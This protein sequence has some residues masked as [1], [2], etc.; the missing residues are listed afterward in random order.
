[1]NVLHPPQI[2]N[3][4]RRDSGGICWLMT[5]TGVGGWGSVGSS[6]PLFQAPGSNPCQCFCRFR[7]CGCKGLGAAMEPLSHSPVCSCA[8]NVGTLPLAPTG[9][10]WLSL[11]PPALADLGGTSLR[12]PDLHSAPH[13]ETMT[14]VSVIN[15]YSAISTGNAC[16]AGIG[17]STAATENALGKLTFGMRS[18]CVLQPPQRDLHAGTSCGTPTA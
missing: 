5:G 3:R 4:P 15:N 14:D 16:Q 6:K 17:C 2:Q 13:F 8:G 12:Y 18:F 11:G 1:M 7:C 10:P 9:C